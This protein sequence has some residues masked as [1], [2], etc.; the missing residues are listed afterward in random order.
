MSSRLSR[1]PKQRT[2][3]VSVRC[4]SAPSSASAGSAASQLRRVAW[5]PVSA[6]L[7][8]AGATV[9]PLLDGIHG[10]VQLLHYDYLPFDV[11]GLH[12]SLVVPPLLGAFYTTV[13]AMTI[14]AD[15]VLLERDAASTRDAVQR[16]RSPAYVALSVGVVAALLELSALLYRSGLPYGT[17]AAILAVGGAANWAAMDRTPQGLALCVLCAVT[18]PGSEL[19]IINWFGWWA[20]AAPDVLGL[21]GFPSWV[22]A[23]YFFY[24]PSVLNTARWLKIRFSSRERR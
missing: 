9:G 23:C 14:A 5:R 24:T 21:G 1:V 10:T 15:A 13:G 19:I 12:S 18:A 16:C 7:F 4:E 17:L 6:S 3:L 11:G 20:Y 22:P 2:I 8:I